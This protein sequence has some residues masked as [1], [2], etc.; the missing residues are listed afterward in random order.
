[1]RLN[2]GILICNPIPLEHAIPQSEIEVVIQEAVRECEHLGIKGKDITPFLLRRVTVLSKGRSLPAN[3]ALIEDNARV[4]AEIAVALSSLS[5]GSGGIVPFPQRTEPSNN[6]HPAKDP[7][8]ILVIGSMAVDLTCMLPH[9]STSP[10]KKLLH[11]SHPSEM[12][13]STGGVAYNVALA[14]SYVS[15]GL[16]RLITAIGDDPEGSWLKEHAKT[17]ELDVL[18]V[19]ADAGTARYVAIHDRTGELIT[20]AA[21]MRIIEQVDDND[22]Q[23]EIRRAK[24][25]W[26]AFDGNL[27]PSTIKCILKETSEQKIKGIPYF[28]LTSH[29]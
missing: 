27:S 13:T 28:L 15:S 19:P 24:P 11:T 17:S 26:L 25:K 18:S 2:S 23:R 4:G 5:G 1:M 10:I 14:A 12:S 8:D 3:I 16:V 21:D 29:V 22:I 9:I 7:A 20:A 6:N